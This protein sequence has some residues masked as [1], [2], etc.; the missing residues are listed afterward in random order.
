MAVSLFFSSLS[1]VALGFC[2]AYGG[3]SDS[4]NYYR[5]NATGDGR[6]AYQALVGGYGFAC[7]CFFTAFAILVAA[8]FYTSPVV[9][10]SNAEKSMARNNPHELQENAYNDFV[11]NPIVQGSTTTKPT[12]PMRTHASVLTEED[13]V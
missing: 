2:S 8:A 4:A 5:K 6:E 12:S 9:S 3:Q 7:F 1:L 11:A 13:D 10:G